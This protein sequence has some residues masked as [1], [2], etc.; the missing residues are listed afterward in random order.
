MGPIINRET[1]R[2]FG[3][4][5]GGGWES[6]QKSSTLTSSPLRG[7]HLSLTWPLP[8]SLPGHHHLTLLPP[9]R[10]HPPQTTWP[11]PRPHPCPPAGS[12]GVR[13]WHN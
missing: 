1:L 10:P 7:G 8:L 3:L 13:L 6:C 5:V 11:H 9:T 4:P 2:L 12:A